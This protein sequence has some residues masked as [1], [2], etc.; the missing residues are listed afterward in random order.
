MVPINCNPPLNDWYNCNPNETIIW[1]T[2]YITYQG[3]GTESGT[4]VVNY[5][6]PT[7]TGIT[8]AIDTQYYYLNG[9]NTVVNPQTMY[10]NISWDIGNPDQ[11]VV[12]PWGDVAVAN[13]GMAEVSG[14][15]R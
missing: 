9:W 2:P 4:N 8:N 6:W 14:R 13:P 12:R 3:S 7:V 15:G 1:P 10:Y 5:Q 11:V